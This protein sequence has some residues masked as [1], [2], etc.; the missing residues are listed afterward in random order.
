[1][2]ALQ[3]LLDRLKAAQ[4]ALLDQVAAVDMLPSDGTLRKIAALESGIAA[5]IAL[6]EERST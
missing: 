6:M 3:I 1:M 5:V 2:E 4:H